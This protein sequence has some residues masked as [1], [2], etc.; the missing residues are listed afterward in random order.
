M[1][2]KI[3]VVDD[4]DDTL[5]LLRFSLQKAGFAVGTASDG[6]EALK[7]VCSTSP[8][9]I[10]LDLMMPEIDGFAVCEMLKGNPMTASIPIIMLTAVT[11]Q[12]S[13][14]SGLEAGADDYLTKPF[15]PK[16]LIVRIEVVLSRSARPTARR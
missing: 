2:R 10:L 9:I 3:L 11:G 1:R 14:F 4:D 6:L 12:L 8:D 16:Q 15:S 13:R 5:E 7:K